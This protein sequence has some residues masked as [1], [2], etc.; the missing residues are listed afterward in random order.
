MVALGCS[1]QVTSQMERPYEAMRAETKPRDAKLELVVIGYVVH[2]G[3]RWENGKLAE[4]ARERLIIRS[5]L[6]NISSVPVTIPTRLPGGL[7]EWWD[8]GIHWSYRTQ[9]YFDRPFQT[10]PYLFAPVTLAPGEST[11]TDEY[12]KDSEA[13]DLALIREVA[14]S[15]EGALGTRFGWWT[16]HLKTKVKMEEAREPN[17]RTTDKSGASP[18]RV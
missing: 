3:Q 14:Y 13:V 4:P 12:R 11:E 1:S 17:K 18:L 9:Q 7:S 6:Q 8:G 10:S 16:G 2:L 15:V 5:F